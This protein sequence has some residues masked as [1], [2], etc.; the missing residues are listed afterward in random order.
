MPESLSTLPALEPLAIDCDGA[1]A[2]LSISPSHFRALRAAGKFGPSPI[3]LG[4]AVRFD[5]AEIRG[6]LAA[7]CPGRERWIELKGGRHD[8]A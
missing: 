6:W 1:A 4:R 2:A 8:R 7:G 5:L 3:R